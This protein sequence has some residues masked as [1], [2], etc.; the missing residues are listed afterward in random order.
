MKIVGPCRKVCRIQDVNS[1]FR[2]QDSR[3]RIQDARYKIQDTG[4][5]RHEHYSCQDTQYAEPA[6]ISGIQDTRGRVL[7]WSSFE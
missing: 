1:G 3:C 4:Y 6:L 5:K 2:M 7:L